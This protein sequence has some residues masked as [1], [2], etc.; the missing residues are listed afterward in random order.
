[1]A[2]RPCRYR[3]G[4]RVRLSRPENPLHPASGKVGVVVGVDYREPKFKWERG[5]DSETVPGAWFVEVLFRKATTKDWRRYR[6]IDNRWLVLE[7]EVEPCAT[8]PPRR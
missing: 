5:A 1:M 3:E 6:T 2:D 4:D 8:S 7:T